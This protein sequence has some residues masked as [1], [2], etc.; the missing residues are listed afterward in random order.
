MFSLE[1]LNF[2]SHAGG[3]KI[4]V[5]LACHDLHASSCTYVHSLNYVIT[6]LKYNVL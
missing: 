6:R 4:L 1:L 2:Y 3:E 5:I